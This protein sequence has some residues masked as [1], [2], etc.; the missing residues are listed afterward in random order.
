M[1]LI[2]SVAGET[3]L[4]HNDVVVPVVGACPNP[5]SLHLLTLFNTEVDWSFHLNWP[6][7]LLVREHTTENVD[8][9]FES[10]ASECQECA[11]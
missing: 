10:P 9:A 4:E 7:D 2:V 3:R 8:L 1:I 6:H 5:C 11:L